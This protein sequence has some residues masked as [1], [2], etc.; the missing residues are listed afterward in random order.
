[1]GGGKGER[2]GWEEKGQSVPLS[3]NA[4]YA[5]VMGRAGKHLSPKFPFPCDSRHR[6]LM[7]CIVP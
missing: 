1:M 7:L 4:D 2:R 5:S 6:R 3:F